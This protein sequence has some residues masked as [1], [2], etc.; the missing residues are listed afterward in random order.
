MKAA[1]IRLLNQRCQEIT[2]KPTLGR[3]EQNIG[4]E[5]LKISMLTEIAAQLA[6]VNEH[7]AKI[8]NPVMVVDAESPWVTL[9][10]HGKSYMVNR[11][12]VE[13]V[14]RGN[15]HQCIV[16]MINEGGENPG[17]WCDGTFEEVCSKLGIPTEER[18]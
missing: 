7:L 16:T 18:K 15:D 12:A 5:S 9:A 13:V 17:R 1:D 6:E 14:E 4:L 11:E 3:K 8:A 10:Y 2:G